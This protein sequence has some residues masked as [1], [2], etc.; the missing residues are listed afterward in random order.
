MVTSGWSG[1]VTPTHAYYTFDPASN[2]YTNVTA[3]NTA[4]DYAAT[5]ISSPERKALI[6]FYNA[7]GGDGWSNK[8]GWKTE[9]LYPD[10]FAMPGT[11][12]TWAGIG[13][14][15]GTGHVT[16]IGLPS[17]NLTGSLPAELG[18][19]TYLQVITLYVNSIGGSLPA[20]LGNLTALTVAEPRQQ[21]AD[22]LAAGRVGEPDGPGAALS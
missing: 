15:A 6:A 9:P 5:L 17:N 13:V 10:G 12:G 14:D 16:G 18:D 8:S 3:D 20:E 1:T 7:T 2:S 21:P 19:L 4:Q 11:E 22:G